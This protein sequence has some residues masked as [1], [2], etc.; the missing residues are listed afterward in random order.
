M[1]LTLNQN[2]EQSIMG[3]YYMNSCWFPCW[4]SHER[5]RLWPHFNLLVG[6][7]GAILSVWLFSQLGI[8]TGTDLVNTF[9]QSGK[10]LRQ[11]VWK[12]NSAAQVLWL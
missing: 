4:Q 2:Y 10:D 9:V 12:I 3:Y 1:L 7:G 6:F 5:I 11:R 8:S